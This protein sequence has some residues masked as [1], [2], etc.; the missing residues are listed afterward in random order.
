[1]KPEGL[2][3]PGSN[4]RAIMPATKPTRMIQRMCMSAFQSRCALRDAIAGLLPLGKREL[5]RFVPFGQACNQSRRRE[6]QTPFYVGNE[7]TK[8]PKMLHATSSM[9]PKPNSLYSSRN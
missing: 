9:W 3:G 5:Q 7:C 1:M 2:F 6:L 8:I 4:W